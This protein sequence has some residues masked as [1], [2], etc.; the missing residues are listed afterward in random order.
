[1]TKDKKISICQV[2]WK[3]KLIMNQK[4]VLPPMRNC[5]NSGRFFCPVTAVIVASDHI[6]RNAKVPETVIIFLRTEIA[7]MDQIIA[8]V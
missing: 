2:K 5:K 3:I 1:M 7:C 4:K 6:K 8:A